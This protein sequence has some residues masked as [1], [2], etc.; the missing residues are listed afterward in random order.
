MKEC[1][2]CY[3]SYKN[4]VRCFGDCKLD[5]CLTCFNSVL[6]MNRVDDIEYSC[7][8]C[9]HTSIKNEDKKFTKFLNNNKSCLKRMVKLLEQ[10]LD[11]NTKYELDISWANFSAEHL[12]NLTP[13]Q[14]YELT[15]G[16]Y[17]NVPN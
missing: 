7:P 6:K 3:E 13:D 12:I 4:G 9:R 15:E 1:C 14:L 2:V 5:L 8:Q 11:Q 16:D 17:E 10:R